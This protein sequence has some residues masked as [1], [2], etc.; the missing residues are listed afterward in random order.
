MRM[1]RLTRSRWLWLA[2]AIALALPWC[3]KLLLSGVDA[4]WAP[5]LNG[6]ALNWLGLVSRKPF[7]EDYVPVLPWLGVMLIGLLAP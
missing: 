5:L 2:G 1:A 3:A 6:R 7:T 4:E